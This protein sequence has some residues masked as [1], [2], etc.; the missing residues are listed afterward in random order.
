[1]DAFVILCAVVYVV[2][3]G[4]GI[5]RYARATPEERR[6]WGRGAPGDPGGGGGGC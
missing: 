6:K 1:M 2:L 4:T 3:V 5:V